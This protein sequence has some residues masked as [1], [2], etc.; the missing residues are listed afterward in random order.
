MSATCA[1]PSLWT[2]EQVDTKASSGAPSD[3]PGQPAMG[4]E[5]GL[6][7]LVAGVQLPIGVLASVECD[8][9]DADRPV[10]DVDEA[11]FRFAVVA[12]VGVAD[13]DSGWN[14]AELTAIGER[15]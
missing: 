14:R 12:L 2:I 9:D 8:P 11:D 10:A 3:V 1:D 6:E 7:H 15:R 5:G 13:Q 4:D